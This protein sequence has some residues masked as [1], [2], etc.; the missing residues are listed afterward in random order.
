MKKYASKQGSQ[1][2]K[3]ANGYKF[4]ISQ[5]EWKRIGKQAGWT[6]ES[7]GKMEE[8][9]QRGRDMEAIH[10]PEMYNRRQDAPPVNPDTP[11]VNPDTPSQ[12]VSAEYGINAEGYPLE[13]ES[14]DGSPLGPEVEKFLTTWFPT[15]RITSVKLEILH[16]GNEISDIKIFSPFYAYSDGS[17]KYIGSLSDNPWLFEAVAEELK[18]LIQGTPLN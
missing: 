15:G 7:Q 16:N 5:D 4:Q 1:L 17:D 3:T 13:W 14:K 12:S 18:P 10:S 11:P 2:I 8:W 6:K 9:K